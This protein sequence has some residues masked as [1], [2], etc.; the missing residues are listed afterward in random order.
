MADH[1][2]LY[3]S[4]GDDALWRIRRSLSLCR[5]TGATPAECPVI[6]NGSVDPR[7]LGP[8]GA[9]SFGIPEPSCG[10][11]LAANDSGMFQRHSAHNSSIRFMIE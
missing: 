2:H 6:D 5:L 10:R 8:E 9:F 4:S 11:N 7:P 1:Q 3:R